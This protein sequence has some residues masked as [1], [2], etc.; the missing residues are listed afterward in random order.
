MPKAAEGEN[1]AATEANLNVQSLFAVKGKVVLVTG[2]G[3][4]IGAMIASG[5]AQNGA[6]V[7]IASRKDCS[8]YAAELTAKGP[9]SCAALQCDITKDDQCQAM[10]K[11]IEKADGQLNVLVNNSGTNFAAQLGSYPRDAFTKVMQTNVDAVFALTQMALP[12]LKKHAS[13]ADPGRVINIASVNGVS[14]PDLDTFAYS[15]SKAAVRML[16]QHL[17]SA[18]GREHVTV[19]TINPGPFMS[20]M[21]RGT[22]KGAGEENIAKTTALGRLGAPEDVAGACLFLSSAAGA[23]LTGTEFALDGGSLVHRFSRM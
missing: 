14:A 2:G 18:L 17:A 11:T 7:Y 22:I 5:F 20:R 13:M 4:G 1:T 19:N 23:Y 8:A 9:G 15:T 16:S 10:L 12:L 21:M 6:K 3:S